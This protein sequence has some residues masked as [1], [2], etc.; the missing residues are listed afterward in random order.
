MIAFLEDGMGDRVLKMVREKGSQL[1]ERHVLELLALALGA[2]VQPELVR[3]LLKLLPEELTGDGRIHP[4]LR[5]V[6]SGLVRAGHLDGMMAL[7]DDL[8]AP[9]FR[10]NENTDGYGT[11]LM[12]E[13]LRNDVPFD[14]LNRFLQ[15]LVQTER[16]ARAYQVA[17]EC[18]A[19]ATGGGGSTP[20]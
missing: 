1:Q 14:R 15:R 5:N 12:V 8:P 11:F 13:M 18:A 16:N 19:K 17:C 7:L 2:K 9:Q 4:V 20:F 10:A 6:L 3:A